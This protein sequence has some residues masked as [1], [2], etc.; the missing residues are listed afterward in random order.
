MYRKLSTLILSLLALTQLSA[1]VDRQ[2]NQID[3]NGN[4][5]QRNDNSN[6]NKHNKDTTKNKEIPK[7]IYAW[8]IDRRFGDIIPSE[9]D[10]LSHLFMNTIQ[11][12]FLWRI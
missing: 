11:Q 6:F 2:F 5:T 9:P 4:V 1:Q 10:T 7:G 8:T 12:R 3:E